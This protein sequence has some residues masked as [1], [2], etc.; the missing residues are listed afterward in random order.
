MAETVSTGSASSG[1]ITGME[2]LSLF[3]QVGLML[4]LAV[5]VALGVVTVLWGQSSEMRVLNDIEKQSISDAITY[6]DQN[7][8]DYKLNSDGNLLVPQDKYQ[9]IE[10]ELTSQGLVNAGGD[11]FLRKDSGFGVSQRLERARLVRSQENQLAN[12]IAQFSGIKAV[13]VHLAIPREVSFV[14]SNNKASASVVLSLY[15]RNKLDNEQAKSIVDLVAAS[16][17]RLDSK[18]VSV[19][20]QYGRLYH[21]ASM[22]DDER[23]S[24]K[25]L[26]A[27][28]VRQQKLT[29][30]IQTLLT[31]ILGPENF[32]V[33]VNVDMDFV[34]NEQTQKMFNPKL[35]ALTSEKTLET[36]NE[37]NGD[38]GVSGA[39][40]NQPPAASTVNQNNLNNL[41]GGLAGGTNS[42][43]VEAERYYDIDT[44]ISHTRQQTGVVKK[45]SVSLGLNF[46]DDPANPGTLIPRTQTDVDR[47]QRLVQGVIGYEQA[48]GDVVMIDSFAFI[49]K[50]IVVEPQP[51]QFYEQPLFVSLQR[52]VSAII[53]IFLL[54]FGLLRPIMKKLSTP[55]QNLERMSDPMMMGMNSG[56]SMGGSEAAMMNGPDSTDLLMAPASK[57]LEQVVRA[58]KVVGDDPK[59]VAALVQNW[60]AE[61]E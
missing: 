44:T 46:M 45:I 26:N 14:S 43:H 17:P 1:L 53:G 39:L 2:N 28:L 23:E 50:D 24:E 9:K 19:T 11:D 42:K 34:H 59:M 57:E 31:P 15:G 61:D 21:S 10:I 29:S 8:I 12:T 54:I 25:E 49:Q 41:I 32:T 20:D 37:A 30:K 56:H 33:Q 22:S 36:S 7:Q 3:K 35:S 47:I 55:Q 38:G 52:P 6:L 27:E 40:S 60:I 13:Q 58:K 5:S 4:G 51:L 18:D 16:I 48:R